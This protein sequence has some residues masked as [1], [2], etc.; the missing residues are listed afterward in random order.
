[1]KRI[2][3]VVLYVFFVVG[4]AFS[5]EINVNIEL[6]GKNYKLNLAESGAAKSFVSAVCDKK[7][8]MTKYGDFEFYS[9]TVLD[10]KSEDVKMSHYKAGYIYYNVN[11]KAVSVAYADHD[12]GVS[13][14][15]EIGEFADKSVCSVL[16]NLSGKNIF[17]FKT[18]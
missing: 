1:M 16:K 3:L 17:V 18:E 8:S 12:L 7:L 14:A 13:E 4:F 15:I 6:D 5:Q 10:Y 11:Y 9:Y 2:G